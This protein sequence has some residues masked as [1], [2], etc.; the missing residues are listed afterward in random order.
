[1]VEL[2]SINYEVSA[3]FSDITR[4]INEQ[5]FDE[6]PDI[7]KKQQQ[8][9]ELLNVVRKKQI[10]RIKNGE[11]TTRNSNLYLGILNET[12]NLLLQTINLLKAERDFIVK[13]TE[14]EK[15]A[16]LVVENY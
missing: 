7:I 13:D 1:M 8:V 2:K 11:A 12:K 15:D 4:A 10:K 5:T 6:I 3:L 16:D 9:I 14:M